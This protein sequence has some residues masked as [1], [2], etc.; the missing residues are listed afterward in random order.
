MEKIKVLEEKNKQLLNTIDRLKK[1]INHLENPICQ[2]CGKT[3]HP[4]N[5]RCSKCLIDHLDSI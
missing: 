1:Y 2:D 4:Q 3:F 5:Y